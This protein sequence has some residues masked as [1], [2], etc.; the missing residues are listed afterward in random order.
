MPTSSVMKHI[1]F[2]VLSA[3]SLALCFVGCVS[4]PRGGWQITTRA[5][6]GTTNV[7]FPRKIEYASFYETDGYRV[8]MALPSLSPELSMRGAIVVVKPSERGELVMGEAA[9]I[10]RRLMGVGVF[11]GVGEGSGPVR[12]MMKEF[13]EQVDLR[14]LDSGE[15][16]GRNARTTISFDGMSF[17]NGFHAVPI[18]DEAEFLKARDRHFAND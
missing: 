5:P 2:A 9:V 6:N 7:W 8:R 3:L 1:A 17:G 15:A 18:P 16:K 14:I 10:G 12:A 4:P 11:T 13:V